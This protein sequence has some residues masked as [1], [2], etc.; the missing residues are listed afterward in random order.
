MESIAATDRFERAAPGR[1][2]AAD[3]LDDLARAAGQIDRGAL[4]YAVDLIHGALVRRRRVF[5]AGNGGSASASLHLAAD[6]ANAAARLGFTSSVV[7][8]CE[9]VV[10]LT[11]IANDHSYADV[12]AE[13]L[14]TSG[15][16]SDVLVLLSVSGQS[17][18][19]IRAASVA[20]DLQMTTIGVLGHLGTVANYLDHLVLMGDGDYGIAEDL[21][22]AFGHMVVRALHGGQ[23]RI[24]QPTPVRPAAVADWAPEPADH[25][26]RD[27]LQ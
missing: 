21:H 25:Q 12:F 3:Y 16:P 9:N 10:R 4:S 18:N 7:A 8:L 17:E 27:A 15:Q 13:Q 14:R 6:W 11:A 22:I 23:P 1:S 26:T 19:L 24:F 2:V 20:R 5:V